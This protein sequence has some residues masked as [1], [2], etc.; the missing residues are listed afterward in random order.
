MWSDIVKRFADALRQRFAPRG[1]LPLEIV[2]CRPLQAGVALYVADV[3]GKRFV[4][5]VAPG[6]LTLFASYASTA[7]EEV[8]SGGV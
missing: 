6:A 2:A 1:R 7:G 4:F 8:A 3:D 5:A